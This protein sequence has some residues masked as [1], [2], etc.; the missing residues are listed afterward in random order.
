M[1]LLSTCPHR[2]WP[3]HPLASVSSFSKST[4]FLPATGVSPTAA[5]MQARLGLCPRDGGQS[6]LGA[7]LGAALE[8]T[9][10]TGLASSQSCQ[11]CPH[12]R[13][14][15][16]FLHMMYVSTSEKRGKNAHTSQAAVGSQVPGAW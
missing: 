1:E 15:W 12:P 14:Q 2:E 10:E 4:W 5:G 8:M 13:T 6:A 16:V 11:Q 7:Q 9:V 3:S